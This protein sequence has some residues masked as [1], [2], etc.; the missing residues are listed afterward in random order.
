LTDLQTL[1]VSREG[2]TGGWFAGH[3]IWSQATSEP[4]SRQQELQTMADM[5]LQTQTMH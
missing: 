5:L 4:S 2:Y 3:E 1:T